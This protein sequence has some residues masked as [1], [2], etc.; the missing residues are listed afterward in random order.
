MKKYSIITIICCICL[1]LICG[2]TSEIN[3]TKEF[4]S[5]LIEAASVETIEIEGN[6]YTP[7]KINEM[8]LSSI[9]TEIYY[10]R[11]D[12]E[13][14]FAFSNSDILLKKDIEYSVYYH[15]K[16]NG[17]ESLHLIEMIIHNI[18]YPQL[19][20]TDENLYYF[21]GFL[22]TPEGLQSQIYS[23][24][25]IAENGLEKYNS[26]DSDDIIF[27]GKYRM[28][29]DETRTP[30]YGE[31][32]EAWK[33]NITKAIERFVEADEDILISGKYDVYVMN[34]VP[35][36]EHTQIYFINEN[37]DIYI[38][39]YNFV[40]E[41]SPDSPANINH[42]SIISEASPTDEIYQKIMA[43]SAIHIE[44]EAD[45]DRS[46]TIST[47]DRVTSFTTEGEE[48]FLSLIEDNPIDAAYLA[49][50]QY[51]QL[52]DET[53]REYRY[54]DIWLDELDYSFESFISLLS[55]DDKDAF[56]KLQDEWKKN[57]KEEYDLTFDI[58]NN[59]TYDYD[60]HL[61][62]I[63][64]YEHAYNYRIAIRERTLYVKYLEYCMYSQDYDEKTI[65][66]KYQGASD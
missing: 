26:E 45:Y 61:G 54:A 62:S 41:V 42:L 24:Y 2:C 66:F 57:I 20:F 17:T 1:L 7:K 22:C 43:L 23:G 10:F 56:S 55:E 15:H 60:V 59:L 49:E 48:T 6:A 35:A 34:F 46:D 28:H 63:Y 16:M 21:F 8:L 33:T 19:N 50:P 27:L 31:K 38:G 65:E 36:D 32:N 13:S 3:F 37:G 64:P 4:D 14:E 40:N 44:V 58:F 51:D 29:I 9:N 39:T 11:N 25:Y 53:E 18:P 5:E 30:D 12:S 52:S 47:N